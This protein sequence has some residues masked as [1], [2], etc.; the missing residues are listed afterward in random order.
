M[1][2]ARAATRMDGKPSMRKR[3]R[4]GAMGTDSASLRMSQA[5]EEANDVA[6]GA[7]VCCQSSVRGNRAKPHTRH[8]DGGPKSQLMPLEEERQVE[9]HAGK[10]SLSNAQQSPQ[11][12][13]HGVVDG[14]GLQRGSDA[15]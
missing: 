15:P 12:D 14:H 2:H 3:R 7:A 10:A 8:E 1:F 5:S 11:E 9:R 6:R 13:Q 4:Q